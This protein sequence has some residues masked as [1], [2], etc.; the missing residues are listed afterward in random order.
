MR[1]ILYFLSGSTITFIIAMIVI[2]RFFNYN[3]EFPIHT[4][5]ESWTVSYQNEQFINTNLE[6]LDSQISD[7]FE[8]GDIIT[9][10]YSKPVPKI[11][12]PFPYLFFK[13][14]FC[15]YEIYLDG[16]LIASKYTDYGDK[17]AFV[18]IG[19]NAIPLPSDLGEKK[20]QIKL[21]VTENSAKANVINPV[22]G[23]FDDLYKH[24][25]HTAMI[26]LFVGIFLM[27]FGQ[28]FL[29]ISAVFYFRTSGVLSQL[30]SSIICILLGFW[31]LT[32]YDAVSLVIEPPVA[33]FAEYASGFLLV[34]CLYL[35]LASLHKQLDNTVILIMCVA[36]FL[37]TLFFIAMHQLNIVHI[38]HF[39]PAY[40]TLAFVS[41]AF[42]F[43]YD[44]IDIKSKVKSS[45]TLVLMIG[46]SLL[47]FSLFIYAIIS[48]IANLVDYRQVP[49][50]VYLLPGGCIFFVITQLLNYF[51][52]M[53]HSLAQKKEYDSLKKIAYADNLTNLPNRASADKELK[54]FNESDFNYC[55][56]SLDLN[57]LKE[58]NDNAG[59]PAGD[60]LLKSFAVKLNDIFAS[61]GMC[62]RIGG[63]EFLVLIEEISSNELDSLLSALDKELKILDELDPEV[64][65]SVSYGYA[66][67]S[68]TQEQDTHSVFM[69]ADKRMYEY[70]NT[71]YSHLTARN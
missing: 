70:K 8:R 46:L 28:L 54:R 23:N 31:I 9:L 7:N 42:L 71:Y 35:L 45:S 18:G 56:L 13:S 48:L 61:K 38:N 4:L 11:D 34:P 24:L 44:Y 58:V 50:L 68:E 1:K 26:P 15:A 3:P 21:Y 25:Y 36:S 37:F 52:F 63:D 16:E 65:H 30:I 14:T 59:H 40:Y 60:R 5:S 69:L 39:Q 62:C 2:L 67:K 27:V 22:V 12:G 49:I 41:M 19:Y 53:T 47:T 64:N 10:I 43:I 32:A 29:I 57:G 66:F 20:L 6:K 17:N 33:T 55:L 51:I